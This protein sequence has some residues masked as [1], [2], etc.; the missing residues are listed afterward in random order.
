MQYNYNI[1]GILF[2][3]DVTPGVVFNLLPNFCK[4]ANLNDLNWPHYSYYFWRWWA[5]FPGTTTTYP[6]LLTANS[7]FDACTLVFD[8]LLLSLHCLLLSHRCLLSLLHQQI[9]HF[10]VLCNIVHILLLLPFLLFTPCIRVTDTY[11]S[12]HYIQY[13][14]D[15]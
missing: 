14:A 1:F 11:I 10:H 7:F 15:I 3:F 9:P 12:S 5:V 2:Y 6:L 4:F 13:D 8:S